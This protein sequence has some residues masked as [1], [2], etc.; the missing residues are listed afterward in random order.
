MRILI[1]EDELPAVQRLE[2]LLMKVR[3]DFSI[4]AK[5]TSVKSSIEWLSNNP[6]PDLIFLDIQLADGLSFSIFDHVKTR[7]AIIFCTAYD[8]YAIRAFKLNSI[9][10]LL[11]PIEPGE[12]E[13]ALKKWSELNNTD[14]LSF[15]VQTLKEILKRQPG[16]KNRFM[17]KVGERIHSLPTEQVAFFFS[18]E[19]A[20]FLQTLDQKRFII[21]F[22]LEQLENML[23]PQKFCR[24]NR[25]Y[26]VSHSAIADIFTF[27]QSRLKLRLHHC[28]DDKILI[29][30]EKVND[31]KQ[32]LDQ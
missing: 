10:Y 7:S 17:I 2:T 9:D 27:S 6:H 26:I 21:D 28:T 20:T 13:E 15:N 11:K 18:Q 31:F 25:K 4:V 23:D 29:S 3:P 30:R 5:L 24:V 32:W 12:L 16:Y 14:D 1:I 19:K 8:Q 22:T